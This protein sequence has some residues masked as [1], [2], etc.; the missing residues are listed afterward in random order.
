LYSDG[1]HMSKI[2]N[3]ASAVE[4]KPSYIVSAC[5]CGI[6]TRWDG[7]HC[8]AGR[9]VDLLAAGEAVPFCPEAAGG[10]TIP[11]AEAE[12][13]GADGRPERSADGHTVLDG[14]GCVMT[15]DGADVTEEYVRGAQMGLAL[16]QELGITAAIL[17]A[18]SSSCGPKKQY[19][20]TFQLALKPGQ[21]VFAALLARHGF[22]IYSE[23]NLD[24][25]PEL[26]PAA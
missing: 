8:L 11:R 6:P 3:D 25:V 7:G 23:D 9:L 14:D 12:I 18:H 2:T 19:D 10:L 17:K 15:I 13:M 22:K 1:E 26:A 5:L 20:G 16:A 24:E 21:G 4:R